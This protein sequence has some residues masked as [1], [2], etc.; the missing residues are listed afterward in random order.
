MNR[1]L[2]KIQTV[3]SSVQGVEGGLKFDPTTGGLFAADSVIPD[4][5]AGHNII[6]PGVDLPVLQHHPGPASQAVPSTAPVLA[7]EGE[8]KLE[9][10]DCYVIGTSLG[11]SGRGLQPNRNSNGLRREEERSGIALVD[12]S[13]NSLESGGS[14]SFMAAAAGLE[15]TPLA[16]LADNPMPSSYFPQA[17]G[18]RSSTSAF[19]AAAG[20]G[21]VYG[22]HQ[23][24]SSGMTA[25]NSSGS[26]VHASSSSSPTI[27][28]ELLASRG[29]KKVED[30]V[31]VS[32]SSLTSK[33]TVKATYKEDTIRFKFE[34]STGC[35]QL[36]EEV[37]GRFRLQIGTF[38][39]KYLDD[40]D[41]W[42]M[43]VND[44]DLQEC[45]DILDDVGS[46]NVKFLVRDAP[47]AMGSSGSSN[48]FLIG[49]S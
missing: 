4:F 25:S 1:S 29:K 31:S 34:P 26:M 2:R 14:G 47:S 11:S 44:A 22:D 10:D 40:E 41:E 13:Q 24:T 43:L 37:A 30:G 23:P 9:D 46:R 33:I 19:P 49:G 20:A 39:L 48:C 15:A 6:F 5:G 16:A 38:Q 36:Y 18:C 8:V 32:S 45:L 42:V 27:E 21:G 7:V 28:R 12:C 17:W 35:S 3:L